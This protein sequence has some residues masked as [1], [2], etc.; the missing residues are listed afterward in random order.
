MGVYAPALRRGI[1]VTGASLLLIAPF[2]GACEPQAGSF[3]TEVVPSQ[4]AIS[5]KATAMLRIADAT[6]NNGDTNGAAT[7]YQQVV[8]DNPNMSKAR[9]S[10]GEALLDKG[11]PSLALR[12]FEEAGKLD[13]S[14]LENKIGAGQAYM[15]RHEPLLAQK[16]FKAVLEKDPANV[17]ALNGLGVALDATEHHRE[18]Q[19]Y[20]KKALQIAP[21]NN[22]VRNNYGL[23]LA[24]SG[25]HDEAV[26]E[27]SPLAKEDGPVGRKA[28]QNLSLSFAM[29]GDF[30]TASRWA[31]VDQKP[32]DIRNDLKVYGSTTV[33]E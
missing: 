18:A 8:E 3:T 6:K 15:A 13:P 9:T 23:S 27:L 17:T 29:R 32:D 7:M 16:E 4:D 31:Q 22:A 26:E 21:A 11:D 1:R 24:L 19:K 5:P 25:R 33:R 20:Y 30:V 10:L 28:R 12:Y 2:I 14:N